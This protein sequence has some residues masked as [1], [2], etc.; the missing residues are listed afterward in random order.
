VAAVAA[1]LLALPAGASAMPRAADRAACR[2]AAA[3]TA[4]RGRVKARCGVRA[5]IRVRRGTPALLGSRGLE[6]EAHMAPATLEP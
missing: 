4:K 2:P 6:P 3:D 5:T 1:T